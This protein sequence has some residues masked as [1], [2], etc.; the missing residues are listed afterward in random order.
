MV[1]GGSNEGWQR[2]VNIVYMVKQ[3]NTKIQQETDIT[4]DKSESYS[5][6]IALLVCVTSCAHFDSLS[7][8]GVDAPVQCKFIMCWIFPLTSHSVQL[9]ATA[10]QTCHML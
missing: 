9:W 8:T 1:Q 7:L 3:T 10:L 4:L 2:F 5:E 6:I